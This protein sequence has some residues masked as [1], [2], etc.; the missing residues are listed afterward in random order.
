MTEPR[1]PTHAAEP[2]SADVDDA[3][4]VDWAPASPGPSTPENVAPTG[5]RRLL[6]V[7]VTVAALALA[8]IFAVIGAARRPEMNGSERFGYILGTVLFGLLIATAA[9]WL[10]LRARRRD[11][12]RDLLS[13][14]IAV[15]AVVVIAFA[16]FGSRQG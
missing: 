15:G 12:R 5:P 2:D 8:Y 3:A 7:V 16:A 1:E 9:R 10:W 11:A 13:P 14:W 4:V 6:G